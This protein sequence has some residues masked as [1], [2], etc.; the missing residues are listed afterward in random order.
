MSSRYRDV[1]AAPKSCAHSKEDIEMRAKSD[2]LRGLAESM[3]VDL[4]SV[5]CGKLPVCHRCRAA[6][7]H[8]SVLA[9][10]PM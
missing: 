4:P 7:L 2:R 1:K 10:K 6:K 8:L 9:M 3:K 5:N